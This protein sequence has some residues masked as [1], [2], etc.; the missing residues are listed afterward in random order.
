MAVI[1]SLVRGCVGASQLLGVEKYIRNVQCL[2]HST[3]V[4]H[5]LMPYGL[6]KH[7]ER[8]LY[9]SWPLSLSLFPPPPLMFDA[10]GSSKC[11]FVKEKTKKVQDLL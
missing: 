10:V 1:K 7:R 4:C 9:W 6:V 11:I 2:P 8:S 5:K 3:G